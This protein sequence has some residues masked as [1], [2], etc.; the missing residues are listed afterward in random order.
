MAYSYSNKCAK[1]L[2]KQAVLVTY[3]RKRGHMFFWHTVYISL[4]MSWLTDWLTR[5][6]SFYFI[7]RGRNWLIIIIIIIIIIISL[8]M[9]WLTDWLTR[10]IWRTVELC[11][12]CVHWHNRRSS[13]PRRTDTEPRCVEVPCRSHRHRTGYAVVHRAALP[14][15]LTD[16]LS[17]H[18]HT[19]TD[20]RMDGQTDRQWQTDRRIWSWNSFH[21]SD[22][23]T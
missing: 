9:S 11:C 19:Q 4:S 18:T 6:T 23:A 21:E 5:S 16:P 14:S 13:A 12:I 22:I 7:L 1:N 20:R 2:C 10:N 15:Q 17:T 3:Q 8:S